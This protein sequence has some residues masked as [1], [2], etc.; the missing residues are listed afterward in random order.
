MVAPRHVR[1]R[2]GP[3][4]VGLALHMRSRSLSVAVEQQRH[5]R[6]KGHRGAFG[7]RRGQRAVDHSQIGVGIDSARHLNDG[8]NRGV[9]WALHRFWLGA[10]FAKDKL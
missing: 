7:G 5:L 9:R 3:R 10:S 6:E 4:A 8:G 1:E 2:R